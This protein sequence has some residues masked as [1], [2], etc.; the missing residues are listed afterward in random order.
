MSFVVLVLQ[1]LVCL[2][3]YG[4]G[5]YQ[6]CVGEGINLAVSQ[7]AVSRIITKISDI[8]AR[9]LLPRYIKFPVSELE[10]MQAK[11]GYAYN[12]YS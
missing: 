1:V 3:F 7:P 5:S 4:H 2:H 8:F 6:T 10:V 11:A 12:K 9:I